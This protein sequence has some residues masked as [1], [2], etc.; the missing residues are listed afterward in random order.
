MVFH[1]CP[2]S[3]ENQLRWGNN[4]GR[5]QREAEKPKKVTGFVSQHKGLR[6]ASQTNI[7]HMIYNF[8]VF[9][10][11]KKPYPEGDSITYGNLIYSKGSISNQE[12]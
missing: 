5:E 3:E 8:E 9:A 4:K 1:S 6:R 2:I 7:K 11:T 10:Q 12:G